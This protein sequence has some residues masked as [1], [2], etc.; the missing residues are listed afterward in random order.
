MKARPVFRNTSKELAVVDPALAN[1]EA[2]VAA[3]A[4]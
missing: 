2:R 4:G 3:A 1:G